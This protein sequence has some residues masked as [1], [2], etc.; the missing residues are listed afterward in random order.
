MIFAVLPAQV[1]AGEYHNIKERTDSVANAAKDTL[2]CA[3][4]HIMHGTQGGGANY[5]RYTGSTLVPMLLRAATILDLCLYCH[6]G[7]PLNL[8]TPDVKG[9]LRAGQTL[10]SAGN[11]AHNNVE[12]NQ[13]RHDLEIDVSATEPPGYTG[14][15]P[16]VT[17]KFGS[18]FNCLF[19]HNQHGN[20]NYR[21]LRYDP[22]APTDDIE[23]AGVIVSYATDSSG[24][25][26]GTD[27][28]DT[29][30]PC[31]VFLDISGGGV[32]KFERDN[33]YFSKTAN[34][35]YNRI[36]E[37]CGKCHNDFFGESGDGNMGGT[38]AGGVGS[39]DNNQMTT[40]SSPWKRHPVG[41]INMTASGIGL[42]SHIDSTN[43]SSIAG[44]TNIRYADVDWPPGTIDDDEQPLCLTC[45]YAHGG[46]NPNYATDSALDHSMLVVIDAGGN[47]NM[48]A[49]ASYSTATG[50]VRNVC[51][52][53]HNH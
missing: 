17:G 30:T 6:D 44:T 32:D 16:D 43:W 34:F 18:T 37:W 53:C 41:D 33:V 3:Q 13:N 20:K 52:T 14:T 2:A 25:C 46:A 45:H 51:N 39:G 27:G 4:C 1:F 47:L 5:L 12:S 29:S 48:A 31:D 40:M 22:G 8:D 10:P 49:T 7:D 23:G 26:S 35:N 28:I 15:W 9:T 21:N 36:S 11:F 50:M 19:C 38:A 42:A 24:E